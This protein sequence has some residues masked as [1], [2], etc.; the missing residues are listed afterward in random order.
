MASGKFLESQSMSETQ[1][2]NVMKNLVKFMICLAI[3][4][5]AIALVAYFAVVL[6]GQQAASVHVPMNYCG[7]CF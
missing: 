5:V 2:I 7:G 3:A 6:P 1:S 4:G